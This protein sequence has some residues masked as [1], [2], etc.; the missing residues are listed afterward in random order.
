MIKCKKFYLSHWKQRKNVL[1][2]LFVLNVILELFLLN[3]ILEISAIETRK[4]NK[5]CKESKET[6]LSLFTDDVIIY[7]EN[8]IDSD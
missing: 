3:V 6:K 2:Y 5:W 7:T 1:C 8:P 4:R